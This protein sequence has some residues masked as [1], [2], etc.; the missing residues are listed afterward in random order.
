MG[1]PTKMGEIPTFWTYSP[2][3]YTIVKCPRVG[4]NINA[5]HV[6]PLGLTIDQVHYM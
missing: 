6:S 1:G 3:K 2:F 5:R 4:M